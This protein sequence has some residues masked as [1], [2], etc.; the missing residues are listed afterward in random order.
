MTPFTVFALRKD[1]FNGEIDLGFKDSPE[2]LRLEG[3]VVPAGQ[4]RV[5][6]TLAIA[7]WLADSQNLCLEGRAT[8]NGGE[9]VRTACAADDTM[10]AFFYK[11]L[12]PARELRL[13][14]TDRP[15][16]PKP[17]DRRADGNRPKVPPPGRRQFQSPMAVLSDLPAKIPAGG[18]AEVQVRMWLDKAEI[19]I[20][21]S[22]PPEGIVVDSVSRIDKG[23]ALVLR[24]DAAKAKLGL[25]GNLIANAYRKGTETTKDGKKRDFRYLQGPLPAIPFEVVER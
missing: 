15:R 3:A 23:I 25:K 4:D 5:R 8:I 13:V 17:G 12:V 10:Q 16:F 18:T 9:V 24:A 14:R 6:V 11:H 22:D 7:P 2:D 1:G 19:Q 20:E 21:L